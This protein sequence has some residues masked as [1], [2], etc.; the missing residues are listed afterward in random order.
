MLRSGKVGASWNDEIWRQEREEPK[1]AVEFF[2]LVGGV[3]GKV[4]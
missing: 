1:T 2:Q 3:G 4:E